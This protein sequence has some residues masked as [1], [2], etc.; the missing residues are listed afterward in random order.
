[1]PHHFFIYGPPGS[2]KSTL[3]QALAGQL[4]LPFT[5]LDAAIE[6]AAGRPI[7]EL[8]AAEGESAFRVREAEQLRRAVASAPESVIALGGGALLDP[9][10]RTLA[11]QSGRILFLETPPAV[12]E[13]RTGAQPGIRPLLIDRAHPA[14]TPLAE[15]LDRRAAHY[16]SFP[17]RLD[18]GHD[19]LE[20]KLVQAQICLGAF[21]IRG[22]GR[23]ETTVR[24]GSGLLDSLGWRLR[25]AGWTGASLVVADTNTAEP[26]GAAALDAIR[27]A[28]VAA[29]LLTIPAGEAHKRLE[30]LARLWQGC[31]EAGL[32][33]GGTVV[34]V[35]GGVVGDLAG[36]AAA[37]WMR[38]VRWI[39]VP[40]TLLAMVDS[41]L[42]GKTAIDLPEGKN[43]VGAFHP[44]ALVLA[45]TLTL[46]TLPVAECRCGLAEAVKHGVIADPGLLA[47]IEALPGNGAA[48]C[49]DALVA[50]A[51]GVKIAI[52]QQDPYENGLRAALNLGHTLG[53]AVEMASGF[54]LRHGEAVAIGLVAEARLAERLGLVAEPGLGDR[55]ARLLARLGLPVAVPAGLDPGAIRRALRLDKKNES[56]TV[57]FAL[58]LRAGEVRT[59][60]AVDIDAPGL[61]G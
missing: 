12:L 25:A 6:Q 60:V 39:G 47:A 57:R 31:L 55:L 17:L 45:D 15:L 50:R 33:R 37:T 16:A 41:S 51:M 4:G 43:L 38:G 42:G 34:A 32:D 11:E 40:T 59:R 8:F 5:D 21:R 35:G 23:Q 28:G 56:G 7:R 24:V 1:M 44:P 2:G 26:Y 30:T 46:Q 22:M 48:V 18:A 10:S 36:F 14:C 20:E 3:G 52:I 49:G 13:A 9:A 53:H 54:S 19:R 58:P 29:T 27:Q 61:L